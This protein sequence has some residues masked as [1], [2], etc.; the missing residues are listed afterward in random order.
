[1]TWSLAFAPSIGLV[2]LAVLGLAAAVAAVAGLVARRRGAIPR[3]LALALVVIALAGPELRSETR[4]ALP[5]V[6]VVV[7][8]RSASQDLAGRAAATERAWRLVAERI[9]ALPGIELREAV[10]DDHGSVDGDGTRLFELLARTLADVPPDRVAGAVMITDGQVHDVPANA[11]ALGFTAP[12]HMLLSG[13]PDEIDRRVEMLE[14]PRFGLVG[15]T[16]PFAFRVVDTPAGAGRAVAVTI[17]RDGEVIE[18]RSVRPGVRTTVAIA[19]PH[20]GDVVV[21]I[22][23][24]PLAGELTTLDNRAT[25]TVEGIREHLRV[26]L[27]SGE[28]HPGERTWRNLLKS[29]A[30]VDLVHFTI[31]RPIDKQDGTPVDEMALI[32]FP[33]R[34]LFQEKIRDFDLIVFDRWQQRAILPAIYLDNI[35]RWVRDGGA[36]LIAAGPDLAGRGSL[37]STPLGDVLPGEP[38]GESFEEPF[39]PQISALGRRHPVTRDLPGAGSEPPAWSRWFRLSGLTAAA[40]SQ[41]LMTGTGDRP[42]LTVARRGKGRVALLTSDQVWLWAR[43]Y[44]GGGPHAPLLRRLAHWLMKQPDLEEEALRLVRRGRDLEIERRTLADSVAPVTVTG[45]DGAERR[46]D[47]VQREPGRWTATT[48]ADRQ[49]LWRAT[50]GTLTALAD[51]GPR[52]PREFADV[53]STAAKVAPLVAAT[54]GA[55]RR[56]DDGSGFAVPRILAR[57]AGSTMAGGD[58]IGLSTSR[59]SVLKSADRTPLVQGLLAVA[60]LLGLFAGAWWREGR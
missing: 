47:L 2:W 53:L 30:A 38:T 37:F 19:I 31:L 18:R 28:P 55:V 54:G 26:L 23:A 14:A 7:T 10:F 35:A 29:D 20:A 5:G 27:V 11:A 46:L 41:T 17:R 33:T 56:L 8:D 25:A 52:D 15:K 58:W 12:V 32:A 39:R 21:E 40:D 57:P 51:V 6:A 13:R 48:P 4:D 49:G 22:E 50:D 60:A 45:P 42:L 16:L 9:G 1:M 44:D 43:G 34:E 36:V 24:E 59:A 3:A